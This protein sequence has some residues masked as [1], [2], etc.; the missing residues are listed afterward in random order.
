MTW[1]SIGKVTLKRKE[2]KRR[3]KSATDLHLVDEEGLSALA[4]AAD[5][6]MDSGG[7]GDLVAANRAEEEEG[8]IRE[9]LD[10]R[11]I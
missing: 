9:N 1:L 6:L 3:T 10:G 5:R 11:L 2:C 7:E 4:D 8:V